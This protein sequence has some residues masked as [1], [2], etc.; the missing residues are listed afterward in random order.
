M[1]KVIIL[2][3]GIAV[4][5]AGAIFAHITMN[6]YEEAEN[7]RETVEITHISGVTEVPLNPTRVA[8]FDLAAW[9]TMDVLGFGDYVVGGATNNLTSLLEGFDV[10]NLGTLHEPNL[11]LLI[12]ANPELI[13][14]SHRAR[15]MYDELSR[16]APTIDLG[17]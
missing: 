12:A 13:I 11:E 4:I 16:I 1:K 17:I 10:P 5:A 3:V 6:S 9:D 7:E 2:L 8:M 15:P 14:I